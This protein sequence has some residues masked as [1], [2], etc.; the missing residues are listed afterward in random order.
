MIIYIKQYKIC[1]SYLH[2]ALHDRDGHD[3][4]LYSHSLSVH[5][6]GMGCNNKYYSL[7]VIQYKFTTDF[8]LCITKPI[9]LF[10]IIIL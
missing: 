7:L 3:S 4:I 8:C 1:F 10:T 5:K 9:K 6:S 2:G